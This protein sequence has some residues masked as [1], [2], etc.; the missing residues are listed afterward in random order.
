MSNRDYRDAGHHRASVDPRPGYDLRSFGQMSTLQNAALDVALPLRPCAPRGSVFWPRCRSVEAART[1]CFAGRQIEGPI[2][3]ARRRSHSVSP[4][5]AA[6]TGIPRNRPLSLSHADENI[7]RRVEKRPRPFYLCNDPSAC[8]PVTATPPDELQRIQEK[9]FVQ[10]SQRRQP[11]AALRHCTREDRLAASR[12]RF[13]RRRH[14]LAGTA[15][16]RMP[17]PVH[18]S[19]RRTAA[20]PAE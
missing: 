16:A 9:N 2:R 18:Y 4:P 1:C 7:R 12:L 19:L 14:D 8:R 10:D 3:T 11:A 6:S 13:E 17:F 15:V 5:N 20:A